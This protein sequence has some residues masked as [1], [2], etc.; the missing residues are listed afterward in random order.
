[1]FTMTAMDHIVLNVRD[2]DTTLDF[3]VKVLGL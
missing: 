2:M 1:M 3:Y